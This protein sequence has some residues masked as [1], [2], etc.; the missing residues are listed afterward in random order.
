MP[1]SSEIPQALPNVKPQYLTILLGFYAAHGLL[2]DTIE[3]RTDLL[4]RVM[5]ATKP[6]DSLV[7]PLSALHALERSFLVCHLKL[8]L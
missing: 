1:T 6:R 7:D 3:S 8:D 4:V 2:I 5:G